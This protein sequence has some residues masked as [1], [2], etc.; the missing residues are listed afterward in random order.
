MHI[1]II[2]YIINIVML[3]FF[4][5]HKTFEGKTLKRHGGENGTYY[6]YI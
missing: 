3:L 4:Q 2:S 5:N 6:I 1:I